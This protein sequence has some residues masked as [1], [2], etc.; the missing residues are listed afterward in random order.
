M[1]RPLAADTADRFR[2]DMDRLLGALATLA[3]EQQV[4]VLYGDWIVKDIL[5]HIAAWDRALARGVDELLAGHRPAFVAYA[6]P[7]GEDE[8]NDRAVEAARTLPLEAVLA[9][10]RAAHEALVARIEALTDEEWVWSS[11][12][13]W[14]NGQPMTVWSLFD[15]SYNGATHYGGH[16]NEIEALASGA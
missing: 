4:R 3:P 14:G 12:F 5:A 15:Y 9:E 16:A 13:R 10:A 8:F 6:S 2:A 7:A 11:P 1:N